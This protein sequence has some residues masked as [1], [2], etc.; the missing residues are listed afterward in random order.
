MVFTEK[1]DWVLTWVL[2]LETGNTH[3]PSVTGTFSQF[4]NNQKLNSEILS[5]IVLS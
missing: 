4:Q 5:G 1:R 3:F 2:E